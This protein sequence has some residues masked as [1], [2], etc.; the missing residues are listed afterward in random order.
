MRL[1][2]MP[3]AEHTLR[4]SGITSSLLHIPKEGAYGC[5]A[6]LRY[7]CTGTT[8]RWLIGLHFLS[9]GQS[10]RLALPLFS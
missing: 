8:A 2:P 5:C 9:M 3:E 1:L 10:V 4:E 6:R 7:V